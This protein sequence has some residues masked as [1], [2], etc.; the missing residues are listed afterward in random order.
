VKL[1]TALRLGRVSNLPTITSNVLAACAL[2][3]VQP[4]AST[5]ALLCFAL[6]LAYVGGMYLND[7]F[8]REHDARVRPERPIPSGEISA[9]S[10]FALGFGM[11]G[12][13]VALVGYAAASAPHGPVRATLSALGLCAAIVLY[14]LHHKGNPLSPV[15]MGAC[16]VLVYVTTAFALIAMPPD[17][18]WLGAGALLSYLIGLTYAAKQENLGRVD[19][20]WPLLFLALP[21]GFALRIHDGTG[22]LLLVLLVALAG[23]ALSRLLGADPRKR[24]IP[25]AVSSFI[26]GI[27]L[28]DGLLAAT[29]GQPTLALVC[30]ACCALTLGA[31]RFIAGT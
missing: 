18:L 19:N 12:A 6:S 11:L 29:A 31:Q 4:A 25:R 3:G 16:R 7:A 1:S 20:A 5:L 30:A 10:V 15:L 21:L 28:L 14:D 2:S 9:R 22:A 17:A 24:D 27:S 8:D 26:A 13:A 23:Y